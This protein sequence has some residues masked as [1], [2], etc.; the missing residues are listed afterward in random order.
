MEQG[1]RASGPSSKIG[2]GASHTQLPPG[3]APGLQPRSG[4]Q[5]CCRTRL[6]FLQALAVF[7]AR[8][9]F[10]GSSQHQGRETQDLLFLQKMQGLGWGFGKWLRIQGFTLP[11]SPLLKLQNIRTH[12]GIWVPCLPA[13]LLFSPEPVPPSHPL[14]A[15]LHKKATKAGGEHIYLI[16]GWGIAV[17]VS[18]YGW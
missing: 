7:R 8:T 14:T 5:D 15:P 11:C 17:S 2:H 3:P 13:C 4:H 18:V 1:F 10:P 16:W 9:I 12:L 6:F